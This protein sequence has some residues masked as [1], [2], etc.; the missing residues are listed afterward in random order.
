MDISKRTTVK[1]IRDLNKRKIHRE[2]FCAICS[3]TDKLEV[4]HYHTVSL[5]V[6]KW[7]RISGKREIDVL[8]WREE[9]IEEHY[10]QLITDVVTLCSK[11]HKHLHSIF[12]ESP[13]VHLVEKQKRWVGIQKDKH[14]KLV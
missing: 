1:W 6:D 14:G 3:T 2:E 4:H 9:F 10:H 7:L 11:H 12:G 8:E 5:L 13:P